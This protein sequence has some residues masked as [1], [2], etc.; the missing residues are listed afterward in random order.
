MRSMYLTKR[1]VTRN[2]LS[3][4]WL[5]EFYM[6]SIDALLYS[7]TVRATASAC[8]PLRAAAAHARGPARHAAPAHAE[9]VGYYET[10]CRHSGQRRDVLIHSRMHAVWK[11]WL[12]SRPRIPWSERMSSMQMEHSP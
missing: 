5:H 4:I 12:Q 2:V 9:E 10:G 6:A 3:I 8:W 7:F 11:M 1:T